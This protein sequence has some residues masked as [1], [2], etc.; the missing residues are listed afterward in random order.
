MSAFRIFS[1]S[2]RARS[3]H[4]LPAD[5]VEK[6]RIAGAES[7]ELNTTRTPFLS[8]FARLLWCGKDIGQLAEVLGGCGEKEFITG[9]AWAA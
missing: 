6:Q 8:G 1:R 5:S 4:L 9:A 2:L 3:E 7:A